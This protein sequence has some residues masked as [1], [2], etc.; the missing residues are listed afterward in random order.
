MKKYSV[1]LTTVLL[2][3]MFG[4]LVPQFAQNAP[5]GPGNP[6]RERRA[7]AIGLM[8]TINTAEVTEVTTYGSFAAWQTLLA[9]GGED[10][11]RCLQEYGTQLGPAPEVLP[12]WRLRLNVSADGKSYDLML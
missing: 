11:K 4:V 9:H 12:G 8:R 6:D 10:M 2:V 7:T 5:T 3:L 1:L